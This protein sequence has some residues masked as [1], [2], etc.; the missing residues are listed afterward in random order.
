MPGAKLNTD[1]WINE[2]I[3]PYDT[4]SHG[5]V[6]ILAHSRTAFQDMCIA[7]AGPQGRA[8][9]LD[10]KW[11]CCTRD[12]FLYHEPLVHPACIFHGTPQNI[13]ILGGGDGAAVRE[14]LKWNTAKRVTMVDIDA[15]VVQACREHLPEMNQGAFEDSRTE[16]VIGDALEYLDHSQDDW[17][18]IISDLSDPIEEGPSFKLFTKEY[19]EQCKRA[20][21]PDGFFVIQAGPVGPAEMA[22]HVRLNKT[23]QAVFDHV[24]SYSSHIPTYAA[25]WGF[26]IGSDQT[27]ETFPIP[28]RIDKWLREKTNSRLKMMDG[29][30]LLGL[31]QPGKHI[32]DAIDAETNIYTL[33]DPPKFFGK[34]AA[35]TSG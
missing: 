31:M 33:K 1:L 6:R 4:Y 25:P 16:L 9:I 23:V 28:E 29:R 3:S 30:T 8:L 34:G 17:D 27:I 15:E 20:L 12:E 13:L 32:R 21:K 24:V 11:Q 10:G 19:F 26:V 2:Y 22:L 35:R 18:I 5:L 14:A 7:D